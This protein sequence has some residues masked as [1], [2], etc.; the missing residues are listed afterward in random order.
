MQSSK[1]FIMHGANEISIAPNN[2]VV[3]LNINFGTS[4]DRYKVMV[5]IM[6]TKRPYAQNTFYRRDGYS[7][8]HAYI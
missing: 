4:V 8:G 3:I 5:T 1:M 2:T 6:V 7:N